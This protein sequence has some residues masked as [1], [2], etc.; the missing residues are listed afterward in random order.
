LCQVSS[1]PLPHLKKL[2]DTCSASP[3]I[4]FE[5]VKAGQ[6]REET[7]E[8]AS[9]ATEKDSDEENS[10]K[11]SGLFHCSEEGCVKSFQR[12]SLLQKHL[13]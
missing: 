8:L 13:D 12:Y 10:E 3:A 9:A 6:R 5:I 2:A 4:S 11:R 1:T 7:T